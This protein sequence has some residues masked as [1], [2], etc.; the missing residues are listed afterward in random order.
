MGWVARVIIR[1]MRDDE[2]PWAIHSWSQ[3]HKSAPEHRKRTWRD[4]KALH[5]Q[6]LRDALVRRD[7]TRLVVENGEPGRG[8]G[9][10]AFSR[11]PSIDAVH[12]LYVSRPHRGQGMALALL[13]HADLRR[14]VTYTFHGEHRGTQ[15]RPDQR[16]ADR[17][18]REGKIVSYVP[19]QEWSK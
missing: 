10:I 1:P 14:N 11:W 7:T 19:Y 12:W 6:P 16:I 9:W 5:L 15:P 18:R 13:Q 17:L 3:G 8:A 4:Y 2:L